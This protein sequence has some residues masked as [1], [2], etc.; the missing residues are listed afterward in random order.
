MLTFAQIATKPAVFQMLTGLSLQAF[1]DLLPAFHHATAQIEH[2]AEERRSDDQRQ[3]GGQ[4]M[5]KRL[6]G[7]RKLERRARHQDQVERTVV[8]V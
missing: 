6:R 8:V 4:P 1:L 2:Q 7:E 5:R 3:A